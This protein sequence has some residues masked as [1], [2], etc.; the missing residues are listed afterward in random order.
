MGGG[1]NGSGAMQTDDMMQVRRAVAAQS[2]KSDQGL[3]EDIGY[4]SRW[5]QIIKHELEN[6]RGM[7]EVDVGCERQG[8]DG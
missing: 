7:R 2:H 4:L 6:R 1:K 5:I 3:R 8:A